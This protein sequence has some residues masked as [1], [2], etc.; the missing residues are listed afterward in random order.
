MARADFAL[1]ARKLCVMSAFGRRRGHKCGDRF[2]RGV[3]SGIRSHSFLFTDRDRW[4]GQ[5]CV[6][7]SVVE[8]AGGEDDLIGLIPRGAVFVGT[9]APA[10]E[11]VLDFVPLDQNARWAAES[12]RADAGTV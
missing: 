7:I 3:S 6:V 11:V 8:D 12:D 4:S 9:G 5:H 2:T 1:G 10:V